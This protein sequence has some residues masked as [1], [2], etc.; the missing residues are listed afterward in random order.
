MTK[1]EK[2]KALKDLG[3]S[4]LVVNGYVG[5]LTSSFERLFSAQGN[6]SM[7]EAM[8]MVGTGISGVIQGFQSG[9]VLGG[10]VAAL[11]A[12]ASIMTTATEQRNARLER[13]IEA[14]RRRVERIE[15]YLS[16]F[17]NS[18]RYTLGNS[19]S[20]SV[21]RLE[22]NKERVDLI[23]IRDLNKEIARAKAYTKRNDTERIES[24]EKEKAL[25]ESI[26]ADSHTYTSQMQVNLAQ[27]YA[28]LRELYYQR[29]KEWAKSN[30]SKSKINEYNSSI[31]DKLQ[32]IRDYEEEVANTLYGIDLK[33]WSDDLS[34]ALVSAWMN[35]TDAA[36]AYSQKVGDIM[37]AMIKK[38]LSLEFIQPRMKEIQ[39][40]MF[41]ADGQGGFMEDGKLTEDEISQVAERVLSLQDNIGKWG[42]TVNKLI[43]GLKE[44]GVQFG[45]SASG[46]SKG[47]QGVTENTAD[48]LASYINGMRADLSLVRESLREL[49]EENLAGFGAVA[50]Q[51]LSELRSISANTLRNADATVELLSILRANTIAGRGFRVA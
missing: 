8:Q 42:D 41:G 22:L 46:L 36:D 30:T 7:A 29:D 3:D 2:Q 27:K 51:Q 25:L 15:A 48:L 14:S 32:E 38:W 50:R 44:S 23:S 18:T 37:N 1:D 24:L 43:D 19:Y 16:A 12:V 10:A 17:D 11:S 21:G 6:E 4:V 9:G 34:D 39:S 40:L 45:D 47:I 26:S 20:R 13:R 49:A 5:E 35:G 28:E 33:G 31:K